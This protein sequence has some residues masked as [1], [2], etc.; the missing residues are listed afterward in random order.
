LN[1]DDASPLPVMIKTSR[2]NTG[3][4][5]NALAKTEVA[6]TATLILTLSEENA[7]SHDDD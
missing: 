2:R 3:L 6:Q 4:L 7:V 1:W 5:R